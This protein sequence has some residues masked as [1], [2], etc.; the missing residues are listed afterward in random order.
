M[1]PI[2]LA[3]ALTLTA[4]DSEPPKTVD[5]INQI[6]RL[7]DTAISVAEKIGTGAPAA[8]VDAA[9]SQMRM[10]L[11]AA[12]EQI[13]QVTRRVGA[14]KYQ[15]RG[16]I[17]PINVSACI[18]GSLPGAGSIEAAPP[19]LDHALWLNSTTMCAIQ[20]KTYLEGASGED[21]A[22]FA[23]AV[24]VMQPIVLIGVA[25]AGLPVAAALEN[26]RSANQSIITKLASRCSER[27]RA[28][29]AQVRYECAAHEIVMSVQPKLEALAAKLPT[30]P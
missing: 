18:E 12:Q 28:G 20:A 25:K 22:A 29:T 2:L 17:D 23:L 4:C 9:M 7:P 10:A 11:D 19:N 14:S 6:I 27:K 24:S 8:D 26:Y 16:S 30:S 15:G 5:E 1:R 21:A 13:R 3:A